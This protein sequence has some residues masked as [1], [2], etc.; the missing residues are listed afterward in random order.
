[1]LSCFV[2]AAAATI[3][4]LPHRSFSSSK[5][6]DRRKNFCHISILMA[7]CAG[8]TSYV[9]QVPICVDLLENS[10]MPPAGSRLRRLCLAAA[11]GFSDGL[12]PVRALLPRLEDGSHLIGASLRRVKDACQDQTATRGCRAMAQP[13][14]VSL[15]EYRLFNKS[16]MK[17]TEENMQRQ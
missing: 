10:A 1:M 9:V 7:A 4:S 13:M 15:C 5:I 16:R 3:P 2:W 8:R 17:G 12:R 14:Q 6:C 11:L